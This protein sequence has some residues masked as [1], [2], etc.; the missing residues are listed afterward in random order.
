VFD[1]NLAGVVIGNFSAQVGNDGTGYEEVMGYF[2]EG[3]K[4]LTGE[5]RLTG[6]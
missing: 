6:V 3:I 2:G 1:R 4:I 5:M